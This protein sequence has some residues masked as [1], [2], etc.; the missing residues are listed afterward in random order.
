VRSAGGHRHP[1]NDDVRFG[2][3][4][5]IASASAVMQTLAIIFHI[6]IPPAGS[7]SGHFVTILASAKEMFRWTY[8]VG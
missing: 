7:E 1:F 3:T 5:I 8:W 6:R 2:T 4:D